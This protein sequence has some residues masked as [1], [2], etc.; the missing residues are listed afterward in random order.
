MIGMKGIIYL[1]KNVENDKIYV[2]STTNL[3]CNRMAK[4]RYSARNDGNSKLYVAMR[5]IGIEKFYIEKFKEIEVSNHQELRAHEA[6][7]VKELNTVKDGYNTRIEQR[8]IQEWRNDFREKVREIGRNHYKRNSEII[9][10]KART[11]VV[12]EC[13]VEVLKKHL[14]Q[15]QTRKIHLK[16]M[17]SN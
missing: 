2:G 12:C 16:L 13:G 9:R 1:I 6:L 11:R 8:T 15:H 5:E 7:T 17:N 10:E 3:L 14:K 4:H